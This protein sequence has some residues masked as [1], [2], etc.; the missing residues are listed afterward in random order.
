MDSL[1][2]HPQVRVQLS[3]F[4]Q[5]PPHALM[6][7]APDGSGKRTIAEGLVKDILDINAEDVR[8]DP[9]VIYIEAKDRS[10]SIEDIRNLQ[11]RL[12]L[13]TIGSNNIRRAI[14]IRAAHNMTH[15]A[16]NALLKLLEE[17]PEDTIFILTTRTAY[18]VLPTIYSRAQHIDIKTPS[19]S[20]MT[21]YFL[22]QGQNSEAI[23]NA[24]RY[25]GKR[26]GLAQALLQNDNSHPLLA[27]VNDVKELLRQPLL[28][29]LTMVDPWQKSKDALPD[30]L[31]T[32]E[33]LCQAGLAQALVKDDIRLAKRWRG[34]FQAS[35]DAKASLAYN[36]NT[37]LLLTNLFL[38]LS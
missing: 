1:L 26:L 24:L 27:A 9:A 3:Q 30:R 36:P 20:D 7:V 17:P 37:K 29:R 23:Q 14:I 33:R 25:S 10:I 11:H 13:K 35:Y 32:L 18:S 5:D 15:E 28:G 38:S 31:D 22:G 12:Q 19:V 16:Q 2:L 8:Q 34:Y 6:L 21:K 4:V